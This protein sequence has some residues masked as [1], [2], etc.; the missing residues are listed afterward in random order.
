MRE[1]LIGIEHAIASRG[2]VLVCG[3]PGT[4]RQL[5][6]RAIHLATFGNLATGSADFD[7]HPSSADPY[8]PRSLEELLRACMRDTPNGRPF[9]VV[10]CSDSDGLEPRL[11]GERPVDGEREANGLDVIGERGAL[12]RALGGTLVLEQISDLPARQQLRLARVLRDG[13]VGVPSTG[14]GLDVQSVDVRVIAT[15]GAGAADAQKVVPELRRRLEQT[16]IEL[17]PLRQRRDDIPAL[18][19]CLL[20]DLCRDINV[21]PKIASTQAVELLA[22]LP[23]PGNV[24]ELKTFLAALV[25]NVRGRLIRQSD[26]LAN[27]RLDGASAAVVYNGTLKQARACFEKDYVSAVLERH[28]GRM[29][30]A[31]KALGIQRTN[32]YRKVRQLAVKRRAP[33]TR[34]DS[35]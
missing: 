22:A 33:G 5:V 16:T 15:A 12:Y 3:E 7:G 23:W 20:E 30:E 27:V 34:C 19:R 11:F 17:P 4:G 25:V 32:L 18:V 2:G 24:T 31:A 8:G 9:V 21:A 14:G 35:V 13:E 10:D 1:A 26:V 29:A 6:A 28:R